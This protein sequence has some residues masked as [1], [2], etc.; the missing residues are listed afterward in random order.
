M[1][2]ARNFYLFEIKFYGDNTKEQ[3]TYGFYDTDEDAIEIGKK[4]ASE[5]DAPLGLTITR[6]VDT[7]DAGDS[8]K[9]YEDTFP[10]QPSVVDRLALTPAQKNCLDSILKEFKTASELG[11]EFVMPCDDPGNVFA[12]NGREVE[13]MRTDANNYEGFER[14]ELAQL[15]YFDDNPFYWM[16]NN[17]YILVK[18]K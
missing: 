12:Y 7:E 17:D 8:R 3:R 1:T 5:C 14:V 4:W 10:K 9:I 18:M 6:F 13:D 11:L 16:L 15:T 2:M